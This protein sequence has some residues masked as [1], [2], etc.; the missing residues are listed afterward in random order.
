MFVYILKV[1]RID[2]V[3]TRANFKDE[4]KRGE[5]MLG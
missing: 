1:D 4:D 2:G 3:A 5:L